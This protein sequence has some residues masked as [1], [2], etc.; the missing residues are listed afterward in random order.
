MTSNVEAA[1]SSRRKFL[2]QAAV[3][4]PAAALISGALP[5][6][7]SADTVGPQPG[8]APDLVLVNGEVLTMD[9][10]LPRTQALAVSGGRIVAVGSNAEIQ[11]LIGP[12]TKVVD[13]EGRTV[14]PGLTDGHN[15]AL[16]G[17]ESHHLESYWL[18]LT[19]LRDALA[20]ITRDAQQRSADAWVAVV[21]GWH[22]D[23]FVEQRPPTVTELTAASPTNPVYVQYLYDYALLND[24]GIRA[25]GL[26]QST[27]PPVPGTQVERD[28]AGQATGRLFGTIGPFNALTVKLLPAT[29]DMQ[30]AALADYL[31]E[32]AGCGITGFIDDSA[33]PSAS[34]DILFALR[35]Q[36]GLPVRAGYRVPAQTPGSEPAF[37]ESLMAFRAPQDP[38]GLTPFVGLGELLTFGTYD[39]T[40][41]SAGFR[42]P[43]P[44]LT[45]LE[46]IATFAASRGIPLEAHAYTDDA[47][48]Q[49]LDVF[50][51]VNQT[52]PI[53]ELRWAMAHL[54]TGTVDTIRRVKALGMALSVQMGPYYEAQKILAED[55]AAVAD[56][57]IARIALDEGVLVAGGTDSTRIGDYR[58]WPALQYHVTGA[59]AGN[60]FVRPPSQRLT[61][62]E[63]LKLYTINS[64]WLALADGDR[65]SLV[66]GKLADI[67]VLDRPY[68]E[69]AESEIGK[70]RSV[71]TLL[72]GTPVHDRFGW[73]PSE[74]VSGTRNHS[75]NEV[76]PNA[77]V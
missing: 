76:A 49:I 20:V 8:F 72:G 19:S 35:E 15:H 48:S 9:E 31:A 77:V 64:A 52:Y 13:V 33:G 18:D 30:K 73:L 66:P 28:G 7:A 62:M 45:D 10:A 61:R 26:N 3:A 53:G 56:R 68:L 29:F 65:G 36:G 71:L 59:S 27:T 75:L 67:A 46:T 50:E 1:Q 42:A 69:V 24:S 32:L 38:D 47:G 58:V 57:A 21:G 74:G 16:R 51:K 5:A 70:I 63:A 23:Q 37:F 22:P 11:A 34:Y 6:T 54:T 55:G 41:L 2:K 60:S 25:L 43:A 39:G 17:G 14:I 40:L 4:V 44:S 12:R